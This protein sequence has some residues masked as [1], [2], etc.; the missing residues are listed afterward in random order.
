MTWTD[1]TDEVE[2]LFAEL[3]SLIKL[4][5]CFLVV[6][7]ISSFWIIPQVPITLLGPLVDFL[8]DKIVPMIQGILTG[9]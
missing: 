5:V 2:T 7:W 9:A 4:T 1:V 8:S 3:Q 6:V